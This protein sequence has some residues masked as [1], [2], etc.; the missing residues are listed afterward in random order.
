MRSFWTMVR[1]IFQCYIIFFCRQRDDIFEGRPV[2]SLPVL[3]CT[4][5]KAYVARHRIKQYKILKRMKEILKLGYYKPVQTNTKKR[6]ES[7]WSWIIRNKEKKY[8]VLWWL[9]TYLM[10]QS[11]LLLFQ[12]FRDCSRFMLL[13]LSQRLLLKRFS[14]K[15]IL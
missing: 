1:M 3:A 2:N 15:W 9:K 7:N 10:T 8:V 13:Y 14:P 11:Y 4:T 6:Y 12:P 5:Y